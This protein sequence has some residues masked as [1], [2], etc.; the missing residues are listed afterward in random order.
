[1]LLK[2]ASCLHIRS[3]F[4]GRLDPFLVRM[5]PKYTT[6]LNALLP[7]SLNEKTCGSSA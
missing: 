3:S 6:L 5:S 2:S 7:S 4:S 1:M